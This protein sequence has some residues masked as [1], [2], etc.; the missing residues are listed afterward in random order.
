MWEMQ[1]LTSSTTLHS[2]GSDQA[3]PTR[4]TEGGITD[5]DTSNDEKSDNELSVMDCMTP[6]KMEKARNSTNPNVVTPN[7]TD[8]LKIPPTTAPCEK[9][10][11]V[12]CQLNN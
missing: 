12:F 1:A 7:P 11:N 2:S 4:I 10:N 8:S 3:S 9:H 6:E 5:M